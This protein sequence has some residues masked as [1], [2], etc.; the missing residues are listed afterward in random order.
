MNEKE[1]EEEE[2]EEKKEKSL[3][4]RYEG[5]S[6]YKIKCTEFCKFNIRQTG[7]NFKT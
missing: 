7:H 4:I 2:E 3:K 5:L 6:I 1:E